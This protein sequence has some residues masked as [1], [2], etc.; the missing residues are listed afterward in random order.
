MGTVICKTGLLFF[1]LTVSG[2]F[3]V[4]TGIDDV[5]MHNVALFFFFAKIG[6]IQGVAECIAFGIP[7]DSRD[8]FGSSAMHHAAA[9][10]HLDVIAILFDAGVSINIR[11]AH[12]NTPLHKAVEKEQLP[13][14]VF[15]IHNGA[16][17]NL[18]NKVNQTPLDLLRY[19]HA[20]RVL[21]DDDAIYKEIEQTLLEPERIFSRAKNARKIAEHSI[22]N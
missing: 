10:G 8:R 3:F 18:R 7:P 21:G 22:S 1:L 15:L 4:A 12:G 20:Q 5:V 9:A 6:N 2:Q 11:D 16:A 19:I 14:I 13:I 17:L